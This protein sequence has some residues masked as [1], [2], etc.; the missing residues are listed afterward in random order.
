LTTTTTTMYTYESLLEGVDEEVKEA[1][2]DEIYQKQLDARK[3]VLLEINR[4][5]SR[6]IVTDVE[7][8]DRLV[9]DQLRI[10]YEIE[11]ELDKEEEEE[12][13]EE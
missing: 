13:E 11:S 1:V 10:I 3:A 2:Y 9:K 4:L 5:I 6:D 12:E 7:T 8:I